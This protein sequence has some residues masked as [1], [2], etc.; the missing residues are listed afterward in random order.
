[1]AV[2]LGDAVLTV[3][4]DT[5]QLK[6]DVSR[7]VQQAGSGNDSKIVG[8][9]KKIAGG[10]GRGL[11]TGA[12]VVGAG[13]VATLG[14][15]MTK[16]FSRMTAIE[17]AQAKL[18]GLG[19]SASEVEKIMKNA[20]AAVLGTAFG[21]DEAATVSAS[22]VAAGIK[23]GRDLEKTLKL[24]ADS[25]TI[26]GTDMNSMGQ[27]FNKVATS[28]KLQGD[29]I[30]QLNERGIPIV[31]LLSKSLGVS[32]EKVYELSKAGKIS[33][34]DFQKAM[35]SGV[36]GA[37][38]KS[39]ETFTGA[40]ANMQAALG[41]LG[42]ASLSGIFPHMTKSVVNVTTFVNNLTKAIG[43]LAEQ[44]GAK[45]GGGLEKMTGWLAK[46]DFGEVKQGETILE[47]VKNLLGAIGDQAGTGLGKVF[48]MFQDAGP[49]FK[50]VGSG[51]VEVV[52]AM[53]PAFQKL[54]DVIP[55][56]GGA[57]A[58]TLVVV[59]GFIADHIETIIK[60]VPIIVAGFMAYR[61][62]SQAVTVSTNALLLAQTKMMPVMLANNA[63]RLANNI[64]ERQAAKDITATTVATVTNTGATKLNVVQLTAQKIALVASTVAAKAAAIATR[65]LGI[66]M[67]V[68]MGPVGWIIAA[69]G[70]LVAGLIL[71][72]KKSETFRNIVN[73]AFAKVKEVAG[74]VLDWFRTDFIGFFTE[75]I[76][77]AFRSVVD[78]VKNNWPKIIALLGGPV[79][80]A[81]MVLTG[82]GDQ[83]KEL[84]T[85]IADG[86][87]KALGGLGDW[88]GGVWQKI[89]DKV[90]ILEGVQSRVSGVF[91][92]VAEKAKGFA[93][94]VSDA[95]GGMF[96]LIVKGDWNGQ[97]NRAFGWFEDN[98]VVGL[99]LGFRDVVVDAFG[100]IK[101][102]FS[103]MVSG[104]ISGGLSALKDGFLNAIGGINET[105]KKQVPEMIDRGKEL[106]GSLVAG[107]KEK[108]PELIDSITGLPARVK[109]AATGW[110]QSLTEKGTE[111][112]QS[113]I[114]GAKNKVDDLVLWVTGLP[115]RIKD[116]VTGWATYLAANGGA[117]IQGVI[118][119]AKAKALELR[120]WVVGLPQ[121]IK[122]WLPNAGEWLKS[123]G[124]QILD[125]LVKGLKIGIPVLLGIVLGI[126]LLIVGAILGSIALL[127]YAG[128]TLIVELAKGVGQAIGEKLQPVF[129]RLT[130]WIRTKFSE[131]WGK[132]S[133]IIT[134]PVIAAG[135]KV[136]K[137]WEGIKAGFTKAKNWVSGTWKNA[138]SNVSNWMSGAVDKGKTKIS[139][140]WDGIK[141]RFTKAKDWTRSSWKN[142]WSNVSSWMSDGV[143]KGKGKISGY[144][145]DVKGRFNKAKE[146][147]RTTWKQSWSKVSG[148]I[149]DAV[150]KGRDKV[151]TFLGKTGLREKFTNAKNWVKNSWKPNWASV[152]D[153]MKNPVKNAKDAITKFLG[154]EGVRKALNSFVDAAETIMNKLKAAFGKPVQWVIN[155]AII[156]LAKA[157]AAVGSKVGITIPIPAE[158][159][160]F[161]TGGVAPRSGASGVVP[162]YTPGRDPYLA[163]VSGGEGIVRPEVT[164]AVGTGWV[165][166]VNRAAMLGGVSGAK[167]F[168]TESRYGRYAGAYASGG[169]PPVP[170]HGNRHT[171]GYPWATWAGDY[172]I[173]MNTAVH[174][175]KSGVVTLVRHLTTSYGKHIRM[176]HDDGTSSL[177]A[178]LNKTLVSVGDKI[179]AGQTIGL[180]DSTGNS[181]GPHL[182][183]ETMGG[184][185][186]GEGSSGTSGL[187]GVATALLTKL[188][189]KVN[190]K[191]PE[192]FGDGPW[193][194]V[195]TALPKTIGEAAVEKMKGLVAAIG[196][197]IMS[198]VS[199]VGSKMAGLSKEQADNAAKI[200]DVAHQLGFGDRGAIIGLITA[201]VES[202]LRNVGYGDRDSV[203]LFQQRAPWGPRGDRM[204]PSKSASMFFNGG[205]G[206]QPGLRDKAWRT[207]GYGALA[208]AVQ[209]SAFPGRYSLQVPRAQLILQA[210]KA[211]SKK[212][213]SGG[214]VPPGFSVMHNATG[215]RE[216]QAVFTTEQWDTLRDIAQGRERSRHGAEDPVHIH[217]HGVID[218]ASAARE[219]EN[220]LVS[221]GRT[222][223]GVDLPS[224][225]RRVVRPA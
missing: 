145:D 119:G 147:T 199:W 137:A 77:N 164:R 90:P 98:P 213:D 118:D 131:A 5:S 60:L 111:L 120:D 64:L 30:N 141:Q 81:V 127:V 40:F 13:A 86:V 178:H 11:A 2:S 195:L 113:I 181:T 125:G 80:A 72:Y 168:L 73:K 133:G 63:L 37:A 151:G 135:E 112:V 95:F 197:G 219:I 48:T 148:W 114:D 67:K 14:Y 218:S 66:A 216:P 180:S 92:G 166:G 46:I 196:D 200:I 107:A 103:K 57:L 106:V 85:G 134:A 32:T 45:L 165:H 83:V 79:G 51:M 38:L 22:A 179:S 138:W 34:A 15:A 28:N 56:I 50:S 205:Q 33:F 177:Y 184:P 39:G 144:W 214:W 215:R 55:K 6:G 10:I 53:A 43:P 116:K 146:W 97:L 49:A 206:G 202:G 19:H 117:L 158:M 136:S 87:R 189:D 78:W 16:G 208:Q 128:V 185:W 142:A 4:A 18:A 194:D 47:S 170:G 25:A 225:S 23:P 12:K 82:H 70:L 163:A 198:G 162:G 9:G 175:W 187:S 42:A 96:A 140:L 223:R 174:A 161:R 44:V 75:T 94:R 124:K 172:P 62:A 104:D 105:I 41:R 61:V 84:F 155:N 153:W 122:D 93:S 54:G 100:A 204:N 169:V 21:L 154:R 224:R 211:G 150:G 171:S 36:G 74:A 26:A 167:R 20:N 108:I 110:A 8:V 59:L 207:G 69:I 183:F 7:G 203:G 157:A 115:Q 17:N 58:D 130:T 24:V 109:A 186:N 121:R 191:M 129:T 176:N 65:A 159:N 139:N 221:R 188:K 101:D 182:H 193:I 190:I 1:M 201:L 212:Y 52:T 152:E 143:S 209:V 3:H 31:Q 89:T 160:Q 156:P 68:A 192:S 126:P 132:L 210:F 76:P 173:P 91:G 222:V 27:I 35:E 217:L 29:V 102:A 88:V 123:H 71:A 99:I 149:S 220:L